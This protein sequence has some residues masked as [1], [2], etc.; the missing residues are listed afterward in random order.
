MPKKPRS[1][2]RSH[3]IRHRPA[4]NGFRAFDYARAR[5]RSL[6]H[7]VTAH[8]GHKADRT[9]SVKVARFLRRYRSWLEYKRQKGVLTD[10]TPDYM[11]VVEA[12]GETT[13]FHWAVRVPVG[14]E[15]E[16]R[17]KCRMWADRSFDEIGP[18]GLMIERIDD[19]R[20]KS[21]AGYML[22]GVDSNFIAHF[23]LGKYEN[24][25]GLVYGRRLWVSRSLCP[26][27]RKQANYDDR[28]RSFRSAA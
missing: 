11:L 13:H 12:P 27:A 6:T 15:D 9:Q 23:H 10:D 18:S 5:G 4:Q 22:K 24:E 20:Y 28:S 21:L 25:Q 1:Q 19:T 14:L 8:I 17:H 16:F 2:R 26:A 3:S 7:A